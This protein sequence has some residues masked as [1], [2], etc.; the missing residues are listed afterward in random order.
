MDSK[1]IIRPS[2]AVKLEGLAILLQPSL[3]ELEP[4]KA[5]HSR[6]YRFWQTVS[7]QRLG[8]AFVRGDGYFSP[9]RRFR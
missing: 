8:G 7:A 3:R 5:F 6:H 2:Q 9:S 1:V 4:Q